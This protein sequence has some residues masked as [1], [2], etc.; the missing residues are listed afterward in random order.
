MPN[1]ILKLAGS[2][3]PP[4]SRKLSVE[5]LGSALFI[6]KKAFGTFAKRQKHTSIAKRTGKF[7]AKFIG[8]PPRSIRDRSCVSRESRARDFPRWNYFSRLAAVVVVAVKFSNSFAQII[9]HKIGTTRLQFRGLE[10]SRGKSYFLRGN[11]SR[12]DTNITRKDTCGQTKV[13]DSSRCTWK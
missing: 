7:G 11:I 10:N 9:H 8:R 1:W 5:I 3:R 12:K 6:Y 13:L 4:A 2:L